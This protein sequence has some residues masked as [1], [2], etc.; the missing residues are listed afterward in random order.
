M[1]IECVQ[2]RLG[3]G[4]VIPLVADVVSSVVV[5]AVA[6]RPVS[7]ERQVEGGSAWAGASGC[8]CWSSW[9]AGSLSRTTTGTW[10]GY[11]H[12]R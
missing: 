2:L 6:V 9:P 12:G 3:S 11:D 4:A 10:G 1:F 8:Q 5:A 7:P